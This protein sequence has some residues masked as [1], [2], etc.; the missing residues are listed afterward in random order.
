M[1]GLYIQ[2]GKMP[3]SC[4]ECVF[5]DKFNHGCGQMHLLIVR[6]Y[7]EN[8]PNWCPMVGVPDHGDLIDRDAFRD[9]MLHTNRYFAV[10]FDI[11]EMESLIDG[12]K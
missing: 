6:R 8:R 9:K 1:S 12:D 4:E 2:G 3:I 10:K 7:N 11:D 5:Y